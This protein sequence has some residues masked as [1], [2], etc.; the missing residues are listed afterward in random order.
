MQDELRGCG[1][2][3]PLDGIFGND[4]TLLFF[5]I[6]FLLLFTNNGRI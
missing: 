3:R 4:C 6:V 2:A 5:I 1:C